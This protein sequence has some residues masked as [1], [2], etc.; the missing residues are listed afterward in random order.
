MFDGRI[1]TSSVYGFAELVILEC[2]GFF[3][4]LSF[5]LNVLGFEYNI[6]PVINF[7]AWLQWD[8]SVNNSTAQTMFN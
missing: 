2:Y 7:N 1:L 3:D 8:R 5:E 4:L 6:L